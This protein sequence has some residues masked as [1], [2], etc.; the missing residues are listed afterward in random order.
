VGTPTTWK[1]RAA[2]AVVAALA[3]VTAL[4][5]CGGSSGRVVVRDADDVQVM[6][7]AEV[8]ALR[9]SASADDGANGDAATG[10]TVPQNV[11]DR[12]VE[13]RLFDAYG[14]FRACLEDAGEG[15]RGD[16]LDQDNPAFRD[17]DYVQLLSK[18]AARTGIV[19]I[20]EEFQSVRSSLTP[21][22]VEE[23]NE[24]FVALQPCLEERGWTIETR[25]NEIGLIEPTTFV[26]PDGIIDE[27]DVQQCI[28][29]LGLDPDALD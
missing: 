11:D 24:S 25:T 27:R 10:S 9:A 21:E 13:L 26:G 1:G 23:R 16:L 2:A 18:C 22:Q 3:G 28:T 4:G 15:I 14:D 29:E 6:S 12:P 5:A 19:E 7:P 20:L 17:P 8:R